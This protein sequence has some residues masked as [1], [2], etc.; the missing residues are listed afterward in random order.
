M[1]PDA[2]TAKIPERD[3]VDPAERALRP[4]ML[5]KGWFPDQLGGLD[6]Y[7]RDLLEHLPEAS[8]VVIGPSGE[9]DSRVTAISG[10][11]RP[12]PLRLLAFWR[13][14]QRAAERA[15]VIDAHFALYALAPLWL[16]RLRSKPVV[17]HFHG[18]WTDE[19]VAAGD[20]SRVRRRV[21]HLIERATYVS[22]DE[23]ITLTSAFRQV[24]V[25][26]YRVAPWNISVVP[27]GVD[28]GRFTP[29]SVDR[30]RSRLDIAP[31]AFVAVAV[32]RLVPRMGLDLLVE[33][34]SQT[35]GDLPAGSTL[36]LVG[37]G[38]MR[39]SLA[40]SV[41]AHGLGGSVR[42]TGRVG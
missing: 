31:Q 29:G 42:L 26:R 12:L 16:G 20:G 22:A 34:W 8:G 9:P 19:N 32:R 1:H 36:L 10:H 17:L 25:E 13:A 39:A 5:G 7:Y 41:A 14:A 35:V 3:A 30:A 40:N 21:R 11:E 28:L 18:P 37:D 23:A 15:D 2:I 6:R 38:P 27:P 4:L 24:L 33:A